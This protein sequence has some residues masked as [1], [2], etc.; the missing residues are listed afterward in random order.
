MCYYVPLGC[1][2]NNTVEKV[3]SQSG[4]CYRLLSAVTE[5]DGREKG[6]VLECGCPDSR[7]ESEKSM[8]VECG[9]IGN[10]G[11]CHVDSCVLVLHRREQRSPDDLGCID[12]I[13]LVGGHAVVS[14]QGTEITG[15]RRPGCELMFVVMLAQV[16]L[17]ILTDCH[18]QARKYLR[19]WV[20]SFIFLFILRLSEKQA[21]NY[22]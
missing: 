3:K 10:F 12:D 14:E 19:T 7:K 11:R 1:T 5:T 18:L 17:P 22:L 9:D 20:I 2:K 21:G 4:H 13:V 15:L 8:T 16:L 6:K